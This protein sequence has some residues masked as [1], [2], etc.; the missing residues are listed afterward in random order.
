MATRKKET[1]AISRRDFARSAAM[2]AAS[3]ACLPSDLLA[4]PPAPARPGG[5]AATPEAEAEVDA[6]VQAILR[7]Y[8]ERLSEAEKAEMRRL[9]IEGQKPL[10]R[11][12]GFALDN[13]DQPANVM[14]IY[15]DTAAVRRTP[16]R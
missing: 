11:M 10:V 4:A 7:K 5:D 6:K 12:R 3:A 1:A 14:K 8:G 2:A 15:P 9:V 13:A 16:P